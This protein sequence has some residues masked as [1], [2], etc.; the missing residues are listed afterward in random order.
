[1]TITK[2]F[3][4]NAVAI[5]TENGQ[6][7]IVLGSGIGFNKKNSEQVDKAKIEKTYFVQDELQT[8]FLRLLEDTNEVHFAISQHII[9]YAEKQG[10]IISNQ[11]IISLTDHIS[12]A[13]QR[14]ID[15]ILLPNLM[16]SEIKILY[17]DEYEIGLYS[18]KYIDEVLNIK[19]DQDEAAYIAL[20]IINSVTKQSTS[21]T[22]NTLKF[23]KGTLDIMNCTYQIDTSNDDFDKMRITTHLKFLAQRIFNDKEI[24]SSENDSLYSYLINENNKHEIF[25]GEY[26]KYLLNEFNYHISKQEIVYLLIHIT[27]FLSK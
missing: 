5:R 27:K 4:N 24:I 23:V 19:L 13:I 16:L 17:P 15:E 3:N 21:N 12:F 18:L 10:F 26:K 8:K 11:I 6:E 9:E 22:V 14:S 20:H 2:I 25:I 1:M 7:M